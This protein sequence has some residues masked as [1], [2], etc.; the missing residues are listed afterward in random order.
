MS[1]AD[2]LQPSFTE[3]FRKVGKFLMF[4]FLLVVMIAGTYMYAMHS[5]TPHELPIA[6]VGDAQIAQGY[7]DQLEASTGDRYEF[8]VFTTAEEGRE[9]VQHRDVAATVILTPTAEDIALGSTYT[10]SIST[11]TDTS[12]ILVY[13]ASAGSA[14]R[15]SAAVALLQNVAAQADSPIIIRDLVPLPAHDGAGVSLVYLSVGFTLTGYITITILSIGLGRLFNLRNVTM[16]LAPFGAFMTLV[17]WVLAD[18]I[19]GAISGS[20]W[21]IFVT[22]WLTI[23]AVGLGTFLLNR[24]IGPMATLVSIFIFVAC[25]IPASG[26]AFPVDMVPAFFRFLHPLLPFTATAESLRTLMYFDNYELINHWAVLAIWAVGAA[27][28]VTIHDRIRPP[29]PAVSPLPL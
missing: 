8:E 17:L 16:I 24:V 19:I 22:G 25:G 23:M 28:L 21:R 14:S 3:L 15:A 18:P 5:P 27:V 29:K 12:S 1:H 26:A 20:F 10:S 4:P 11:G 2:T 13:V 6:I 9:Q 7:A